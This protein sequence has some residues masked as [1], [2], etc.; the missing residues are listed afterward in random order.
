MFE[1]VT[2]E[3]LA[4]EIFTRL[5]L[6]GKENFDKDNIWYREVFRIICMNTEFNFE[7]VLQRVHLKFNP[8]IQ[9]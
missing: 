1:S 8:I 5:K 6:K 2:E 3:S 9:S 7:N 4:N